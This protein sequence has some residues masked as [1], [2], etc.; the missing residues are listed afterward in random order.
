LPKIILDPLATGTGK[1]FIGTTD[2]V[3]NNLYIIQSYT[4]A[5]MVL[6]AVL[7]GT[8][9][10]FL[11]MKL[12]KVTAQTINDIKNI[13]TGGSSKKW[14]LDPAPGA[15]AIVVGTEGS[16]TTYFAGGPIDTNCQSDDG[17]TFSNANTLN[18]DANGS[19]FNGGNIAP[20][21]NCGANRSF[22]TSFTFGPTTGGVAGL[23]TI[24]L[25]GAIPAQFIGTTDVPNENLY[26]ILEITPTKLVLRAGNGTNT[27][28]TFKFIPY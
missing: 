11:E 13:L 6:R 3:D 4:P 19:T 15:N 9:G 10:Q 2:V 22:T 24:Q 7:T 25:P 14:K 1:P 23:A 16:P 26:R 21:Y 5:N 17:Y 18:Y 27:I 28:F 12:K 8:G 20:N